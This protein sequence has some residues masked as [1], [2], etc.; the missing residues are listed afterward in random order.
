MS[1]TVQIF[2]S[3]CTKIKKMAIAPITGKLRKTLITDITIAFGLGIGGA[4]AYW[5]GSYLPSIRQRDNYYAKL[6]REKQQ[7]Q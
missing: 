4:Y 3:F 6:A 2:C 7:K 5:Y 1:L